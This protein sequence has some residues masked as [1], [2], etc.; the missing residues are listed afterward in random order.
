M[1]DIQHRKK[2]KGYNKLEKNIFNSIKKYE[3]PSY[4][5]VL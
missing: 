2:Q 1:H 3:C 5:T 4:I